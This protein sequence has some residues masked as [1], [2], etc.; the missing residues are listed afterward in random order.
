ML[1]GLAYAGP[2]MITNDPFVPELGQFEINLATELESQESIRTSFPLIDVNYGLMENVQFTLS[3]AYTF[4]HEKDDIDALGVEI[5][6]N[7][8]TNEF[9]AVALNPIYIFYPLNTDLDEGEVYEFGLPV[10]IFLSSNFNLV[11]EP[12][13]VLP[14]F[15]K[16]F[17]EGGVYLEYG[18]EKHS[19]FV[20]SFFEENPHNHE[21]YTLVNLGYTYQ[22]HKQVL[23]MISVGREIVA[24]QKKA[25]IGYSGFQIVF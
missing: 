9:F 1:V 25:T 20:E 15:D 21:I 2:P 14:Q 10:N 8:Y 3:S 17:F 7:F 13:Y 22:F 23:F 5:K 24:E 19:Y 12:R 16:A 6:W 18:Q 4:T 11:L